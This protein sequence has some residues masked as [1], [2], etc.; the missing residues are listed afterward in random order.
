MNYVHNC[1][2]SLDDERQEMRD[3][4]AILRTQS[5]QCFK[6]IRVFPK[7]NFGALHTKKEEQRRKLTPTV[8]TQLSKIE[9]CLLKIWLYQIIVFAQIDG[10]E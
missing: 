10:R 8:I 5:K 3:C 7:S 6:L 9:E 4:Q 1:K 2:T